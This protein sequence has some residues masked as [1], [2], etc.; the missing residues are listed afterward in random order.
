MWS[1]HLLR[2]IHEFFFFFNY[3]DFTLH[4][5]LIASQTICNQEAWILTLSL[6]LF[7]CVAFENSLNPSASAVCSVYKIDVSLSDL[8]ATYRAFH[9]YIGNYIFGPDQQLLDAAKT[10]ISIS[11]GQS[12]L[13]VFDVT[14]LGISA[15]LLQ[16]WQLTQPQS[17]MVICHLTNTSLSRTP[18]VILT[19]SQ[20]NLPTNDLHQSS[21]YNLIGSG[22]VASVLLFFKNRWR[23]ENRWIIDLFSLFK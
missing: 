10:A 17:F 13:S 4:S 7:F 14:Q 3:N 9:I 1:A 23:I 16:Y 20:G 12:S 19:T 18:A 15:F 21:S 8:L 11:K 5:L 22:L 2:Y 6:P